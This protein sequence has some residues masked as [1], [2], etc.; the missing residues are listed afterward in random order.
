[1]SF[2][3]KCQ[4]CGKEFTTKR[5]PTKFCGPSCYN[6][7]KRAEKNKRKLE[8]I[9]RYDSHINVVIDDGKLR[10]IKQCDHCGMEFRACRP[11]GRFCCTKCHDAHDRKKKQEYKE[12]LTSEERHKILK[13]KFLPLKKFCVNCGNE[14]TAYKQTTMF[15]SS[16]C[17]KKYR[18]RQ[19]L[20]KR[21]TKVTT[22]SMYLHAQRIENTFVAK[23]VM[24]ISDVCK[25]LSLSRTT[26]YRYVE[27]GIIKPLVLPGM[28]LFRKDSLDQLFKDGVRFR[29]V[30]SRT[31]KASQATE[32]SLPFLHSDEYISI[33]EAAKV[34]GIPLNIAQNCLR[35]SELPYEKFRNVRIYKRDD[36]DQFLRKRERDKHPEIWDWYTVEDVM[37][38]Y[39]MTR[40][41]VYNLMGVNPKLPRKKEGMKTYYSKKHVDTLLKPSEDLSLYYTAFEVVEKYHIELRRLYKVAKRI[42]FRSY[43]SSGRIWYIKED[44]DAFFQQ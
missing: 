5:Y 6:K 30:M 1:M 2:V 25:Y 8:L 31:L 24:R 40:K 7:H 39:E 11:D 33:S 18:I 14:F 12:V 16:A 20:E 43:S 15:C 23:D 29:E 4:W 10:Y 38:E 27:Q 35:R 36:V 21:A 3:K 28:L 41:Q 22:E 17:A 32:G 37:V 34:Y 44:V 26:L 9:K 19:K 42:G 13:G